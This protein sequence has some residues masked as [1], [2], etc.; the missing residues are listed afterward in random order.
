MTCNSL[1][2]SYL[3]D[4]AIQYLLAPVLRFFIYLFVGFF[5]SFVLFSLGHFLCWYT[6]PSFNLIAF[7]Y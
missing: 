5:F 4:E 6:G 7:S 2:F 3:T 1:F